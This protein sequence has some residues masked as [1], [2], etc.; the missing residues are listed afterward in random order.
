MPEQFDVNEWRIHEIRTKLAEL[1]ADVGDLTDAQISTLGEIAQDAILTWRSGVRGMA[2]RW[3][4]GT[5]AAVI[6]VA[7]QTSMRNGAEPVD[8]DILQADALQEPGPQCP[9]CALEVRMTIPDAEWDAGIVAKIG[10]GNPW[11]YWRDPRGA[12]LP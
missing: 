8:M 9:V 11:H 1:Y 2:E 6:P 4:A 7:P 3:A 12:R 5:P 10:C